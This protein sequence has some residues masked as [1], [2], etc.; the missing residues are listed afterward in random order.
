M[1]GIEA[2]A[3]SMPEG[4]YEAIQKQNR[5]I[6]QV[7][8][9]V[10]MYSGHDKGVAYRFFIQAEYDHDKSKE[11]GHEVYNEFDC[12][13]W[14]VDKYMKPVER[15]RHLPDELLTK[16]L[17]DEIVGGRYFEAY[18]RFKEKKEAPGLPLTRWGVLSIGDIRSLEDAGIYSVEQLAHQPREKMEKYPEGI[19]QA[20][21]RATIWESSKEK[22]EETAALMDSV[23]D[24]KAQA[25]MKDKELKE[26][27]AMILGKPTKKA[28]TKKKAKAKELDV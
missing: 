19:K 11:R 20:F 13:E 5:T 28:A 14:Q 3:G 23:N 17:Q 1:Q 22:I 12:I 18:T 8:N 15:V 25:D 27:R 16:N 7:D 21:E 4:A 6:A 26:L 10:N 2:F 24:L 9:G